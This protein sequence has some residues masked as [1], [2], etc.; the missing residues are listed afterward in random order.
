MLHVLPALTL[1]IATLVAVLP[2]GANES[3]RA[4]ISFAPLIVV[5]Y[6]SARRPRLLPVSFI[7]AAGLTIDVLTHG[8]VGYWALMALAAAALAQ[9]EQ[10]FTGQSSAAGRAAVF[11]IAMLVVGSLGWGVA[12]LYNGQ[13]IEGRPMLLAALVAIAVYPLFALLLMP[14]DRLWDTHRGHLFERGG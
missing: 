14:I 1:V 2:F 10:G 12:S 7:F 5:H 6:W 11:A 8:P 3:V 9:L 4:C 13:L